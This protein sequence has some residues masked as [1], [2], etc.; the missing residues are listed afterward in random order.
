MLSA[1]DGPMGVLKSTIDD[2]YV[3]ETNGVLAS[4]QDS[5]ESTIETTELRIEDQ[6]VRLEDYTTFLREKFTAMEVAMSQ[7]ESTGLYLQGLF[8]DNKDS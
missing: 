4:R 8:A 6:Q 7:F 1:E 5:L 3:D 2:T